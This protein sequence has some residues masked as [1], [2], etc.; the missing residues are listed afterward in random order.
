MSCGY[1][2]WF[3]SSPAGKWRPRTRLNQT[4]R[5]HNSMNTGEKKSAS[6]T[7]TRGYKEMDDQVERG[8]LGR[9][10][11]NHERILLQGREAQRTFQGGQSRSPFPFP[12]PGLLY[13]TLGWQLSSLMGSS[14]NLVLLA[15]ALSVWLAFSCSYLAESIYVFYALLALCVLVSKVGTKVVVIPIPWMMDDDCMSIFA[16]YIQLMIYLMAKMLTST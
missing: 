3:F 4:I 2:C 13:P 7:V 12:S 8:G 11:F 14:Q 1:C 6:M 10:L 16:T 5:R 9:I 15:K